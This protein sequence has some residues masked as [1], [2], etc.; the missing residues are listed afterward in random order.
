MK[1]LPSNEVY[2]VHGNIP[3]IVTRSRNKAVK[4]INTFPEN[5]V[6]V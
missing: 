6:S 4:Y 3:P 2:I 1:V 5:D